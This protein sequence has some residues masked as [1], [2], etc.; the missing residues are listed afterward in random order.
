MA[1]DTAA[2][3][4]STALLD[5][6]VLIAEGWKYLVAFPVAL[7][8]IALLICVF[9]PKSYETTARIAALEADKASIISHENIRQALK[10]V[11]ATTPFEDVS[12][13]L[14]LTSHDRT[15]SWNGNRANT[16]STFRLSL[17]SAS[18][19]ESPAILGAVISIYEQASGDKVNAARDALY[20]SQL[21]E[22]RQDIATRKKIL[23]DL[24]NFTAA[25]PNVAAVSGGDSIATIA[26]TMI[27]L[28]NAIEKKR[29]AE[30]QVL[31]KIAIT[32][33]SIVIDPPTAAMLVKG[34]QTVN[35]VIFSVLAGELLAIGF[36]LLRNLLRL[37]AQ[38]PGGGEK[39]ARLRKAFGLRPA[40]AQSESGTV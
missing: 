15:T 13:G 33:R 1:Q 29:D 4:S 30:L 34:P 10:S 36:V 37:Q 28:A 16:L 27:S 6:L 20:Q 14:S 38:A 5:S 32:P 2:S 40:H 12:A 11:S 7:G 35:A 19:A 21:D 26:S 23:S 31:Y 25:T 9:Q 3:T 18:A 24:E 39:V 22:V 8:L 17:K